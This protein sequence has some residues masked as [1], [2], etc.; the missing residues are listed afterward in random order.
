MGIVFEQP[1]IVVGD[2]QFV[3]F[4]GYV[5]IPKGFPFPVAQYFELAFDGNNFVERRYKKVPRTNGRVANLQAVDD[6]VR[7]FFGK[8]LSNGIINIIQI[9]IPLIFLIFGIL[10][11]CESCKFCKS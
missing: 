7:L 5:I 4:D 11:F 9:P 8:I 10:T 3:I 2:N 1:A 6:L